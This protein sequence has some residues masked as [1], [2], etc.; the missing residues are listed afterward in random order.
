MA[1]V[2][3]K[4]IRPL[5]GQDPGTIVTY[6]KV[7]A[8]QLAALGAVQILGPVKVAQKPKNK[9]AKAPANK[10]VSGIVKKGD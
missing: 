3:V 6:E 5:N 8:D 10:A 2:K 4:L 7:D 9:M 1:R